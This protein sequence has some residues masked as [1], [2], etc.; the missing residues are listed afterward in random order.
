M[1]QK[2]PTI[3][4]E[5]A[6]P[7]EK[8]D[9]RRT[10]LKI[11]QGNE[12]VQ[13][14]AFQESRKRE[15]LAA[16]RFARKIA[17]K[18]PTP[19]PEVERF[20]HRLRKKVNQQIKKKGGTPFS[21]LRGLFQFFD[22][23]NSGQLDSTELMRAMN[24]ISMPITESEA[25][26]VVTFY[27]KEGNGEFSYHELVGAMGGAAPHFLQ[28]PESVTS[29]GI[30]P[31]LTSIR[32]NYK[33]YDLPSTD[34]N[35]HRTPS[36]L[37][38]SFLKKVQKILKAQMREKG[39]TEFSILRTLFLSYDADNSGKLD[40]DELRSAMKRIGITLS[41]QEAS[42]IVA[43]YGSGSLNEMDYQP[44]VDACSREAPHYMSHPETERI[45]ASARRFEEKEKGLTSRSQ[46]N[47]YRFTARPA[48]KPR[49]KTVERFKNRLRSHLEQ[50]IKKNG[51]TIHSTIRNAFLFWDGDSSGALSPWEFKGAINRIG[52]AVSEE[53]CEQIVAHYDFNGSGEM[54]YERLVQDIAKHSTKML[55]YLDTN[56][57]DAIDNMKTSVRIPDGVQE[58]NKKIAKAALRASTKAASSK[59]LG[60][61]TPGEFLQG[62]FLRFD[63]NSSGKVHQADL[64]MIFQELRANLHMPEVQ[65]LVAWYDKDGTHSLYYPHL[66]KD[67]SGLLGTLSTRSLPPVK[68]NR[69]FTN[70]KKDIERQLRDIELKEKEMTRK[71]G[72]K[73]MA[74]SLGTLKTTNSLSMTAI[75]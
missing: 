27:D 69:S 65:R 25:R 64:P 36:K 61:V 72:K 28:H 37:V 71:F 4:L 58:I 18:D 63:N 35:I 23:D 2:M 40:K 14:A 21:V 17:Q 16:L 12:K 49:N 19:T 74:K 22:A 31:P 46:M 1:A 43:F 56:R 60:A 47:T 51:S 34:R 32:N 13:W 9:Y 26:G 6:T 38:Q 54:S 55:D 29:R 59:G 73:R 75:K 45:K 8:R 11:E 24:K 66:V 57:I 33:K 20:L 62:T 48:N 15:E 68:T 7:Q 30:N 3:D 5:N 53:E 50:Q 10:I 67:C 70:Q 44:L 39:G 42:E 41:D 52:M